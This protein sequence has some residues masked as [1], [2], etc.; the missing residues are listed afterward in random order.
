MQNIEKHTLN[1]RCKLV[2]LYTFYQSVVQCWI[3]QHAFHV[4]CQSYSILSQLQLYFC[5]CRKPISHKY[6]VANNTRAQRALQPTSGNS[7][8]AL[9]QNAMSELGLCMLFKVRSEDSLINCSASR[10][11]DP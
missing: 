7:S 6:D 4:Q 8:Q 5:Y 9:T 10:E 1:V 3:L 2:A 11:V